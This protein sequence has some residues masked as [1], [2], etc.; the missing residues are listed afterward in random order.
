MNWER[1]AQRSRM[2]EGMGYQELQDAR[3][4]RWFE[5]EAQ[6]EA[7]L[8]AVRAEREAK[9]TGVPL[10]AKAKKALRNEALPLGINVDELG[11]A[12]VRRLFGQLGPDAKRLGLDAGLLRRRRLLALKSGHS[13]QAIVGAGR[14]EGPI[15]KAPL[16]APKQRK[17]PRATRASPPPPT[18]VKERLR[19]QAAASGRSLQEVA[20]GAPRSSGRTSKPPQGKPAATRGDPVV[21]PTPKRKAKAE[22]DLAEASRRG[23]TLDQL[24]ADR[25]R[26]AAANVALGAEAKRLGIT[27][28]ELRRRRAAGS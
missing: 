1:A 5:R 28:K 11:D 13:A 12:V 22:R 7:R 10:T 20:G 25:R 9:K 26:I 14:L 6:R 19:R 4:D 17:P 3:D 27:A 24:L 18:S 21:A 23:I 16:P 15:G 8:E 2:T